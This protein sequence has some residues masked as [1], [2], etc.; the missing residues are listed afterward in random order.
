MTT[1]TQQPT[2]RVIVGGEYWD[3]VDIPSHLDEQ[4]FLKGEIE[5]WVSRGCPGEHPTLVDMPAN[6]WAQYESERAEYLATL[7]PRFEY[8]P[9]REV[10]RMQDDET[11]SRIAGHDATVY[12]IWCDGTEWDKQEK[13]EF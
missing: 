5:W 8:V 11:T 4:E 13:L 2:V 6:E 1:A 9:S 12:G 7:H 10:R 3:A